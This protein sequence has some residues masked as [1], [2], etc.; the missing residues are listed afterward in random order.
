MQGNTHLHSPS[1]HCLDGEVY[2]GNR[3]HNVC[4]FSTRVRMAIHVCTYHVTRYHG[5]YS[6]TYH[7]TRVHVYVHKLFLR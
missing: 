7:G 4:E 1:H 2:R 3:H 6:S 5:T